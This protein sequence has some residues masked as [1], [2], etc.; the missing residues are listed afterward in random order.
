LRQR[1][2]T[3]AAIARALGRHRSTIGREVH[4]NRAHA[5]GTYRPQLAHWYACGRRSRSRRNRQFTAAQ[6]TQIQA[7][8]RDDW[9]PE[10]EAGWRHALPTSAGRA[11]TTPQTLRAL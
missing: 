1:G 2:L 4:R 8:L 6:W 7:L 3:A 10:P 9:S 5:D 11:Q